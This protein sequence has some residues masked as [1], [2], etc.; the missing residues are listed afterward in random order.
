MLI[1]LF[2]VCLCSVCGLFMR[3]GVDIGVFLPVVW[4][5]F[6][7]LYFCFSGVYVYLMSYKFSCVSRGDFA[8]RF[9]ELKI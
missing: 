9:R 5:F 2:Q 3:F 4:C 7:V 1:N 6:F 8:L